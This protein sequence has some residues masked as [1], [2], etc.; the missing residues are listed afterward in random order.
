MFQIAES[1]RSPATTG[2]G[3]SIQDLSKE[4]FVRAWCAVAYL[5]PGL[6]PDGYESVEVGGHRFFDALRL[7]RGVG[8]GRDADR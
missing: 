6:H 7:K 4:N 3:W 2:I 8:G 5:F 1:C